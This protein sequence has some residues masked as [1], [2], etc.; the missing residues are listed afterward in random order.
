M[1]LRLGYEFLGSL[2][3][4]QTL[5]PNTIP[6]TMFHS[7]GVFSP[8]AVGTSR[9]NDEPLITSYYTLH[10]KG[11]RQQPTFPRVCSVMQMLRK[12]DAN[13]VP[14]PAYF[15]VSRGFRCFVTHL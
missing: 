11:Q 3:A 8:H 12:R 1:G 2:G 5:R 10:L 9:L 7:T 14:S 13:M 15:K 6:P 4:S